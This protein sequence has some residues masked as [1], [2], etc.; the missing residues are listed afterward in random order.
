MSVRP[1]KV[2]KE[3]KRYVSKVIQ[4]ELKD[5]RIGFV[6]ITDVEITRDLRLAK[7]Y[8]SILGGRTQRNNT[9]NALK[10]AKGYIKK[11]V[12]D[13][14]KLRYTPDIMFKEDLSAARAQNVDKI[15]RAIKKG[16]ENEHKKAQGSDKEA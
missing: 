3:L 4:E 12:G 5:P 9:V 16:K 10:N 7:V 8:F 14:L 1:E 15:L 13:H 2:A 11:L 6:T